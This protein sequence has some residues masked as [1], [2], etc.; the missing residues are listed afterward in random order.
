M[1]KTALLILSEGAEEMEAIISADVLRRAGIKVTVAGLQGA[2]PTK[3][4]RDIVIVPD[5]G[6]TDAAKEN[7]DVVILPGGLQGA[8]NLAQSDIVKEILQ[9]QEKNGRLIAA[10][11][12]APIALKSHGIGNG[13]KITSYPGKKAEL[14]TGEYQYSENRVVVDEQLITSRGPGTAFEFA[15]TIVGYLLGKDKAAS[16]VEPMLIKL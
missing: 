13:K 4:S 10:I 8:E 14:S 5:C 12:A 9:S 6:I 3:C 1:S 15:L 11:C 16:M 7:Y 2:G